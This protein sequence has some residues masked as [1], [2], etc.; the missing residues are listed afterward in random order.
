MGQFKILRR[1][2]DGGSGT[3]EFLKNRGGE[4][5]FETREAAQSEVDRLNRE[6]LC[7]SFEGYGEFTSTSRSPFSYHVAEVA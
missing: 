1:I 5:V 7:D 6:R 4:C 3:P 2:R